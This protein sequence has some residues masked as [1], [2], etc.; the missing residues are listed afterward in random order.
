MKYIS[1]PRLDRI[2]PTIDSTTYKLMEEA[3]DVARIASRQHKVID[4]NGKTQ[5]AYDLAAEL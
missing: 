3:G 5:W 2:V 1:L 4:D